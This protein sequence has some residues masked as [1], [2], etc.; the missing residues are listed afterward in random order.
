MFEVR[1]LNEEEEARLQLAK[2]YARE[3]QPEVCI[4]PTLS[5][6]PLTWCCTRSL[7]LARQLAQASVATAPVSVSSGNPSSALT[8]AAAAERM[9]ILSVLSRIYVGSINFELNESHLR[10][11]FGQFGGIKSVSLSVDML[12]GHHKGF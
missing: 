9:R 8:G 2:K 4:P 7:Q 10:A 5:V 6:S 11:V 1:S 12:T 3:I